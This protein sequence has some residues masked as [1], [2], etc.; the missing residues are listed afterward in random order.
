M[1]T[2]KLK[3]FSSGGVGKP[4]LNWANKLHE[5]SPKPSDLS[6]VRLKWR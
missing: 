6:M 5:W 3:L 1:V 4:S 2:S